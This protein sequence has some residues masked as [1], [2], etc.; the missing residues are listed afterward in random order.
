MDEVS[1]S[2]VGSSGVLFDGDTRRIRRSFSLLDDRSASGPN[3][4]AVRPAR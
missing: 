4:E 1:V 3:R 2:V